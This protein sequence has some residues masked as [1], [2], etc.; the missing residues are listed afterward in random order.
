MCESR[1]RAASKL[2][3]SSCLQQCP[4]PADERED[5]EGVCEERQRRG[6]WQHLFTPKNS[7]RRNA[8][9]IAPMMPTKRTQLANSLGTLVSRRAADHRAVPAANEGTLSARVA[10]VPE[11]ITPSPIANTRNPAATKSFP[12]LKNLKASRLA[13]TTRPTPSIP[14]E[15][16]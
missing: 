15:A 4:N 5:E 11:S 13:A 9:R 2:I 10:A 6:G 14:H 8:K 7:C 3:S 1:A 12:F 16:A